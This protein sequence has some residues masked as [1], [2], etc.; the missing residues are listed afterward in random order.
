MVANILPYTPDSFLEKVHG[1]P[2]KYLPGHVRQF[3]AV[4]PAST[5]R[6]DPDT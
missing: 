1:L 5:E 4:I 2:V 6:V 3:N